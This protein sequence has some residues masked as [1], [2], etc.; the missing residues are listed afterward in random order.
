MTNNM[1]NF[2]FYCK[3]YRKDIESFKKLLSSFT[4]YNKDSIKFYLSVPESDILLFKKIIQNVDN[5]EIITDESY[6]KNYLTDRSING[7][8]SGYINQEICKLSFWETGYSK[9]YLLIDSDTYFIKEFTTQDFMYS[10]DIPYSVLILDKDLQCSPFYREYA[11]FRKLMIDKIFDTLT[12][13]SRKKKYTCHNGTVLNTSVLEGFKEDWMIQKN[14]DYFS[15]IEISPYEYSWYNV[16]LQKCNIIEVVPTEPFFK[17]Y[18][19]KFQYQ[20]D[21]VALMTEDN[22]KS[23]YIGIVMNSNW[24]KGNKAYTDPTILHK[25]IN[26]LIQRI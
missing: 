17:M 12:P 1:L 22:I 9:N 11:D 26:K 21:R 24:N 20:L 10:K 5:I 23:Q 8:S 7:L 2:V 14:L 16:W 18:H 4:K 3:T 15:L 13:N 25:L 19:T 6:A